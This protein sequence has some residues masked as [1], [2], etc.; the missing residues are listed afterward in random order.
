MERKSFS[1]LVTSPTE[2]DPVLLGVSCACSLALPVI[3]VTPAGYSSLTEAVT[4][5]LAQAGGRRKLCS[6]LNH[7]TEI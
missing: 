1:V 4:W 7:R 6:L 2:N 3:A 5:T